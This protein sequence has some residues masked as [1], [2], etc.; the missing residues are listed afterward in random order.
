MAAH[1]AAGKKF[2]QWPVETSAN[3]RLLTTLFDAILDI[4]KL[5]FLLFL[6]DW[7][8]VALGAYVAVG[9][10]FA[11]AFAAKGVQALDTAARGMPITVRLLILPGA[12]ALWP[13]L[14]WKWQRRLS[15]P[16]A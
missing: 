4:M 6:A 15:P 7:L 12:A 14:A 8:P 1:Q 5:N 2:V 11:V 13:L 3:A 10:C 16:V 9:V